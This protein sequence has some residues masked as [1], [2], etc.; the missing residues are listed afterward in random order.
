M[1][2]HVG[3]ALVAQLADQLGLTSALS[4][5]MAHTRER[6]SAHDPGV[7][8]AQLAVMLVDGGDCLSDLAVLRNQP[9][10][11]GQV[12]SNATAW[13]VIDSIHS[14]GLAGLRAARASARERAWSA[15]VRPDEFV[16]DVDAT[17]VGAHSEKED[18]APNYEHGFGFRRVS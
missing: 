4:A 8:L 17:L 7:V 16:L 18:A 2:G 3:A 6:R 14:D 9:E 10:L 1:V 13:R 5:G 11:F 15:D 12:A